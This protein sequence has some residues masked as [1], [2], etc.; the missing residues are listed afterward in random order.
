MID[1]APVALPYRGWT[2]RRCYMKWL[3]GELVDARYRAR[4]PLFGAYV[5]AS[6]IVAVFACGVV[7]R[8]RRR[9]CSMDSA[10]ARSLRLLDR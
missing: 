6:L 3:G 8:R 10:W 2:G 9:I 4:R 1:R 7:V 5:S